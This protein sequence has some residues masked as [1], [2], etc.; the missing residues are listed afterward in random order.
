[1][2]RFRLVHLQEISG[3]KDQGNVEL[4]HKNQ[5]IIV[6]TTD[7]LTAD[8][9]INKLSDFVDDLNVLRL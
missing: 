6:K 2:Q 7:K 4:F 8:E 3:I 5:E 1:M 9:A